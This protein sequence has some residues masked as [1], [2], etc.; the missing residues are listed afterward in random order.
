MISKTKIANDL[1]ALAH[2]G[3]MKY[4]KENGM[5]MM[6]TDRDL[7]ITI[8]GPEFTTHAFNLAG[9]KFGKEPEEHLVKI[10]LVGE[11][12]NILERG[13]RFF[14]VDGW[15]ESVADLEKAIAQNAKGLA[16]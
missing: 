16:K 15:I 9:I 7:L 13:F 8:E 4:G 2:R 5:F 6:P 1:L 12:D 10:S 14:L 11:I 3:L